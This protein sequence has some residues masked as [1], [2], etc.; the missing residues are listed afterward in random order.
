L[1]NPQWQAKLAAVK[2]KGYEEP[3]NWLMSLSLHKIYDELNALSISRLIMMRTGI[4]SFLT[5][6]EADVMFYANC[7]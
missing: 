6:K 1:S 4:K 5:A 7:F 3:N 2:A